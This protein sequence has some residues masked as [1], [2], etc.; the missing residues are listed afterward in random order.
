ML[1]YKDNDLAL[2]P[3]CFDRFKAFARK[4][5][6]YQYFL[7]YVE[8]RHKKNKYLDRVERAFNIMKNADYY[9]IKQ[10]EHIEFDKLGT[11]FGD[12]YQ[13]LQQNEKKLKKGAKE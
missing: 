10:L 9:R 3:W 1:C 11:L 7:D 8:R 5:Q 12:N 2:L 13:K 4:R 6:R